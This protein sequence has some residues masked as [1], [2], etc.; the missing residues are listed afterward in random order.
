MKHIA[1]KEKELM[2]QNH[3]IGIVGGLGPYAGIEL[4][5]KITNQTTAVND[6]DHVNFIL[7]ST[8]E[9]IEDRTKYLVKESDNNPGHAISEN[10]L[11][12]EN[13]GATVVGIPCNTSHTPPIYNIIK[14]EL[15]KAKSKVKLLN[16]IDETALFLKE[17]FHYIQIVGVLC[18]TGTYYSGIYESIL[19]MHGIEAVL[20]SIDFQE[21]VVNKA[22]YDPDFGLKTHPAPVKPEAKKLIRDSIR[23]LK[24]KGAQAVILGCTELPLAITD[25]QI[26][27]L[28]IIDSN[29]VLA[30]ALIKEVDETKLKAI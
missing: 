13:L 15:K 2:K 21:N 19:A 11:L 29:L 6:Q 22:I 4:C 25:R 9:Q 5:K 17:K 30:R 24:D 7:I 14:S 23:Y 18:T 28:W 20:P 12:L 10:I 16:M 27:K 8:P 26:D 1:I 3:I